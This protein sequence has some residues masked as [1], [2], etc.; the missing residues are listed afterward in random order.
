MDYTG[1]AVSIAE[2]LDERR[3]LLDVAYRMVG[4]GDEAEGVVAETYRR[5]YALSDTARADIAAPRSW[6][7][8]T[9][10][11]I[12]LARPAFPDRDRERASA[13][14]T[15]GEVVGTA[16]AA[17][18]RAVRPAEPEYAALAARARR[19]LRARRS[20]P[21]ILVRHDAL[22]RAVHAACAAEDLGRLRSLLSPD[23]TAVFDGGGKVRAMMRPVRGSEQVARSLLVL[24]ARRPHTTLR[25]QSVNGRTGLVVRYD[26]QVAAIIS[27]GVTGDRVGHLW[28]VL[29]PDKLRLW[30]R[31][32]ASAP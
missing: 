12:C 28:V 3:Q 30:N 16:P 24:L 7:V 20:R 27:L 9:A 21:G 8:T 11:G 19:W 32:P 13:P 18:P 23:A 17:V 6:L 4:D 26:R 5:W 14:V 15:H 2:L 10:R 1:D 25:A 31:P 29:N 22:A